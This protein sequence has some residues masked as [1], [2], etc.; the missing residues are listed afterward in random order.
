MQGANG[1]PKRPSLSLC[2]CDS[3]RS[4]FLFEP[5]AIA[6]HMPVFSVGDIALFLRSFHS[7]VLPNIQELAD[8]P[9]DLTSCGRIMNS[10]DS[11]WPSGG[12]S[13]RSSP[14]VLPQGLSGA[15]RLSAAGPGCSASSSLNESSSSRLFGYCHKRLFRMKTG[16]H[17]GAAV[18]TRFVRVAFRTCKPYC[19][20]LPA[21]ES[22]TVQIKSLY[23]SVAGSELAFCE[24]PG[25][26]HASRN[27][28]APVRES[29]PKPLDGGK[30][31]SQLVFLARS[32]RRVYQTDRRLQAT[33]RL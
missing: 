10:L 1:K 29:V 14:L 17:D 30:C 13:P 26:C 15:I 27:K 5:V 2:A 23:P 28:I 12:G 8:Q 7:N 11:D 32:M 16:K 22:P 21:V 20:T 9:N 25:C 33:T 19:V 3:P 18:Q 6:K 24:I 4:E 31:R